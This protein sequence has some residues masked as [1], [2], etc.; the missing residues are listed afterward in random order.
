MQRLCN[1]GTSS[2]AAATCARA[3]PSLLTVAT[4]KVAELH[5]WQAAAFRWQA[6]LSQS[7]LVQHQG[8]ALLASV[9]PLFKTRHG[10]YGIVEN[11]R[12]AALQLVHGLDMQPQGPALRLGQLERRNTMLLDEDDM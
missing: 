10:T 5:A 1:T 8:S 3:E 9:Q 7:D 4:S 11:A 6:L 2:D 12:V